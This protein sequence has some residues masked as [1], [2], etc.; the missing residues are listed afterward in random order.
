V[1]LFERGPFLRASILAMSSHKPSGTV[2]VIDASIA[3]PQRY[4]VVVQ[5]GPAYRSYN[6]VAADDGTN[7]NSA[8]W[9]IR[10]PS[11]NMGTSRY[12][13]LRAQGTI[14]VTGTGLNAANNAQFALRDWPLASCMA[15]LTCNVD[16]A[17]I[18]V[19]QPQQMIAAYAR[20]ANPTKLQ[21]TTQSGSCTAPDVASRYADVVG[22]AASPFG[23][24]FDAASG[25]GVAATRTSQITSI[26]VVSATSVVIGFDITEPLIISPFVSDSA[27][28]EALFGVNTIQINATWNAL[29]RMLCANLQ[30]GATI[31]GVAVTFS[32]QDLLVCYVTPS[33][34]SIT[35]KDITAH[36]SCSDFRYYQMQQGT[37][38]VGAGAN[39][40]ANIS[41]QAVSVCPR[42]IIMWA[43]LPTSETVT[44]QST[45][46]QTADVFL[47]IT[48]VSI[49]FYD[50]SGLLAGANAQQLY[51]LSVQSGLKATMPEFLGSPIFQARGN[52][53]TGV[54]L[55]DGF[56]AGAPVVID[57]ASLLSLPDHIAPGSLEAT[58]FTVNAT[59]T[60]ANLA[61]SN[62][63]AAHANLTSFNL[64][65]LLVTDATLVCSGGSS[66]YSQLALTPA[67]IGRAREGS[68]LTTLTVNRLRLEATLSG[69]SFA[70]E[71]RDFGHGFVKGFR[72]VVDPALKYGLPIA[73]KALGGATMSRGNASSLMSM[74]RAGK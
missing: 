20:V 54:Q 29:H 34:K 13:P 62:S 35:T 10:A 52:A 33:T 49:N 5:E 44:S 31:T 45:A 11:V 4:D 28:P 57:V 41:S 51:A 38:T 60:A 19:Q 37:L 15:N 32:R 22:T 40:S 66:V 68:E 23:S 6:I 3:I 64:N 59:V 55:P 74:L 53:T 71:L 18:T 30:N 46:P 14:T 58:Q 27:N 39:A 69:G 21:K 61:Q 73:V 50:K 7:T 9:T 1:N 2:G 17:N 67:E 47:P 72:T 12:L 65:L 8:A 25:D 36:Y 16:Q 63:A 70:S 56:Y 43:S 48:N 26:N 24:G 42:Q